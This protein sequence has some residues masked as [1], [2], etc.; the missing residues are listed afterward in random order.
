MSVYEGHGVTLHHADCLDV[1]RSVATEAL[2][3]YRIGSGEVT[4]KRIDIT[5]AGKAS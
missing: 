3:M 2:L 1:L 5:L 4:V